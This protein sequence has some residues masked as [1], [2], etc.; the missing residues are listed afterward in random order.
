MKKLLFIFILLIP[1]F[2]VAQTTHKKGVVIGE[3]GSV[4][5]TAKI[6]NDSLAFFVNGTMFRFGNAGN[7]DQFDR[8]IIG[9]TG[10]VDYNT[11][12]T[13]GDT[14]TENHGIGG[15]AL[16]HDAL[17]GGLFYGMYNG[18]SI[19]IPGHFGNA[20]G[21]GSKAY[22]AF[23]TVMGA[24][25]IADGV[26]TISMGTNTISSSNDAHAE[27]NETV[28]GRGLFHGNIPDLPWTDMGIG[29]STDL[30]GTDTANYYWV[31]GDYSD[32]FISEIDQNGH[33]APNYHFWDWP[34]IWVNSA[35]L[36]PTTVNVQYDYYD[37]DSNKT[38]IYYDDSIPDVANNWITTNRL[39]DEAG[40]GVHTEGKFTSALG[41]ASHA[42]GYYT[43]AHAPY[44]H[45]EGY[46]TRVT[47][48]SNA[49]HSE[50]I[51]SIAN[52]DGSHAQNYKTQANGLYST[53]MGDES[54]AQG[55]SSFAFG[56]DAYAAAE[57]DIAIGTNKFDSIGDAQRLIK[58]SKTT[59][60]AAGPYAMVVFSTQPNTSYT[61]STLISGRQTTETTGNIGESASYK[62]EWGLERGPMCIVD[63]IDIATD[64][65]YYHGDSLLVDERIQWTSYT[66]SDM[67]TFGTAPGGLA[68]NYVN[69]YVK[70]AGYSP[71][72]I[73]ISLTQGG[74]L[75]NITS[76]QD[77]QYHTM[78]QF[79][80]IGNIQTLIGRTFENDGD[81]IGNG[82][83]TGIRAAL[84]SSLN[85][86]QV[87]IYV[88]GL[89][90]R[91]IRWVSSSDITSLGDY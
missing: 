65:V 63:S 80:I 83:T 25:S 88:Y 62:I 46:L 52:N 7:V 73:Q 9:V 32:W 49:A 21:Y 54:I 4:I 60:T 29:Y 66:N 15:V 89:A 58:V 45:S 71:H 48:G 17:V 12:L 75:R 77:T 19:F 33:A 34:Y 56:V 82:T 31:R 76:E 55:R 90:D 72:W 84:L 5:D 39:N 20:I 57:G 44:S 51:L 30:F 16:K 38:F 3:N 79:D 24:F 91:T 69:M 50:G 42:E 41:E 78:S 28:T 18:D 27:G 37:A 74:A 11:T 85:Y 40:T 2:V 70:D 53:A 61:G 67:L 36:G 23:N 10:D 68:N 59:G 43:Q 86:Y 35:S 1:F 81:D 13:L 87:R 8:V 26:E 64:K 47:L 14:D 22:G 6:V